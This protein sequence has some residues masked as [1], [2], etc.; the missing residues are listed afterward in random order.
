MAFLCFVLLGLAGRGYLHDYDY[1][2]VQEAKRDLEKYFRLY[3]QKRPHSSLDDKTPDEF[4][5]ENLPELPK[6]AKALTARFPLK[7]WK[8]CPVKRS[9][10]YKGRIRRRALS[11]R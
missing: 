6:A 7:K 10:L 8:N 11:I 9:H 1:D 3:N 5:F 2:S 4:Y